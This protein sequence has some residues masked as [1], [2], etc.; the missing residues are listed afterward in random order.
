MAG[1]KD[2]RYWV[3]ISAS[4][5]ALMFPLSVTESK[6]EFSKAEFSVAHGEFPAGF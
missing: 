6:A 3:I 2:A 1:S 5:L 4:I